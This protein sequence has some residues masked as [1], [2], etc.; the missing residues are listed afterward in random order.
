MDVDRPSFQLG[1]INCFAEMV[2]AGV[3][4]LAISPPL[5]PGE[6]EEIRDG[7]EAIVEGSGIDSFLETSLL[8][9]DLQSPEFTAGRWSVLFFRDPE[10]LR[11]YQGLKERKEALETAG[12]YTLDARRE[13]SRDFMRLLSY[14][15]E[16]ITEKLNAGGEE[17]PFMLMGKE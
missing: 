10:V 12:E 11:S 3:K 15:E 5:S 1:M 17:D 16:T 6:Y 13:I 9:T 4:T 14:P 2:A 8:I 7:I